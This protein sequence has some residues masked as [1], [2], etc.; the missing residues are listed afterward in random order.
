MNTKASFTAALLLAWIGAA[1]A[2]DAPA[3]KFQITGTVDRVDARSG[4][5][6]IGDIL[7]RLSPNV[8]VGGAK[9]HAT[10][11]RTLRLGT[12]VGANSYAGAS[13]GGSGQYI[14][15]IQVFP[16]NFDLSKV[17]VDD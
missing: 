9:K 13:N 1:S 2:S 7:Y 6:V 14:Y 4:E 8:R 15:E 11:S 12:K 10:S 16:D 3:R 17:A 5:I